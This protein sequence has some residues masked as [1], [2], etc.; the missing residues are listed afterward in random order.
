MWHLHAT[1]PELIVVTSAYDTESNDGDN[2]E[3][4]QDVVNAQQATKAVN[5]SVDDKE[6]VVVDS[7]SGSDSEPECASSDVCPCDNRR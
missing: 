7:D 1:V 6:V 3:V 2:V 5:K 4:L